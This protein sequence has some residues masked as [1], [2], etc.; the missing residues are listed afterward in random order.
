MFG[1]CQG[2]SS[3]VFSVTEQEWLYRA[4]STLRYALGMNLPS[5]GQFALSTIDSHAGQFTCSAGQAFFDVMPF[6]NRKKKR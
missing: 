3:K 4:R 1:F 2:L 6:F 5:V